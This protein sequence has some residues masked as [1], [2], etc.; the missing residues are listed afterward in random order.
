MSVPQPG[1]CAEKYTAPSPGIDPPPAAKRQ[2][3]ADSDFFFFFN[4]NGKAQ[5]FQP[6][7]IPS[8]LMSF[9]R[10]MDKNGNGSGAESRYKLLPGCDEP[11]LH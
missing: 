4:K 2:T 10:G 11:W 1:G 9:A 8:E 6:I 7:E 5:K 3:T